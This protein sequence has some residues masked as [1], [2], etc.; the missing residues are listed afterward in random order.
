MT[1]T[2]ICAYV[3][4]GPHEYLDNCCKNGIQVKV[5]WNSIQ[6]VKCRNLSRIGIWHDPDQEDNRQKQKET[7]EELPSIFPDR[8]VNDD[9]DIG[10]VTLCLIPCGKSDGLHFLY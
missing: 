1:E 7:S 8:L 3:E 6:L 9:S 5:E 10:F 2:F 4:V